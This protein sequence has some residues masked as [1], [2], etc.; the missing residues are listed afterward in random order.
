MRAL[1][2]I[3]RRLLPDDAEVQLERFDGEYGEPIRLSGVRFER[4]QSSCDDAHRSADAGAGTLFVDAVNTS[5]AFE[6]PV[7]S[8]VDVRGRSYY[9][10]RC[11][12]LEGFWGRAH[13]W[14]LE[15][16]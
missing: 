9:V 1:R 15:L 13:H 3:P 16:S 6:V 4:A 12:C 8:R 5:G 7:G 10:S 14:E 2:P 11:E